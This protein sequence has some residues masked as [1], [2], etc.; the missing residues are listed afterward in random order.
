MY[1]HVKSPFLLVESLLF[2]SH[3]PLGHGAGHRPR[4]LRRHRA[5]CVANGQHGLLNV[6]LGHWENLGASRAQLGSGHLP[7][8]Q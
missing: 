3:P 2:P 6:L 7:A 5:G 4:H 1:G 8:K